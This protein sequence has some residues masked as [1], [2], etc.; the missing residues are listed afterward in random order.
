M[1]I[2]KYLYEIIDDY[3]N[4]DFRSLTDEEITRA[5]EDLMSRSIIYEDQNKH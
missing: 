1:N 4:A 2:D 5:K 3:K